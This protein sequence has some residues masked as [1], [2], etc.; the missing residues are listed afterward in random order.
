MT[1]I[2]DTQDVKRGIHMSFIG[3]MIFVDLDYR[4]PY[5]QKSSKSTISSTSK[6]GEGSICRIIED[7]LEYHESA[8]EPGI[9]GAR[10]L[11]GPGPHRYFF[12]FIFI[13]IYLFVRVSVDYLEVIKTPMDLGT[14]KSRIENNYYNHHED[15]ANDVRLVWTNC[16]LYNRDGSEV[17]SIHPL[18]HNLIVDSF[19]ISRIHFRG[20]L[21]M[22]TLP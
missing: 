3:A 7:Y 19:I 5:S 12:I 15:I 2:S 6:D 9:Q 10:G 17:C 16:M 21:R 22:R 14:I 20:L 8:R 4:I 18:L 11:G 1:K 13:S